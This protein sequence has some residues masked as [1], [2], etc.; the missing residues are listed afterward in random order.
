MKSFERLQRLLLAV[1]LFALIGCEDRF[2][3]KR[4]Y[5]QTNLIYNGPDG[6]RA[7]TALLS[8]VEHAEQ[9]E[10]LG[11]K[12]KN[13]DYDRALSMMWLRL[14]STY[15]IKGQIERSDEAMHQAIRYFDR[16]E[17]IAK[18]PGYRSDQARW[19]RNLLEQTERHH[20]PEWKKKPSIADARP[21]STK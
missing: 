5:E 3:I 16:V 20:L 9:N 2:D 1:L 11:R 8:F 13:L 19:L 15:E 12:A 4:D 17:Q 6:E 21:E 18:D 10:S 14:A 7:Q